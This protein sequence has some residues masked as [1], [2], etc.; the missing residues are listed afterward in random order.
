MI[1]SLVDL[2][3]TIAI[4]GLFVFLLINSKNI[5]KNADSIRGLA[6]GIS[7]WVKEK[8]RIGRY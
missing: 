8:G 1:G 7:E 4:I 3:Q 6:E 5:I 2:F